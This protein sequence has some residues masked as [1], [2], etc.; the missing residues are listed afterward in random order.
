MIFNARSIGG[1]H[2]CMAH[3]PCRLPRPALHLV[4]LCYLRCFAVVCSISCFS[5]MHG[6][7]ITSAAERIVY[8]IKAWQAD[9]CC[10]ALPGS[11]EGCAAPSAGVVQHKANVRA[12]DNAYANATAN[13]N[14]NANLKICPSYKYA[15]D[16]DEIKLLRD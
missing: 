6:R 9:R 16:V 14:A 11:A 13:A 4:K 12:K 7:H 10:T 3:K 5:H 8:I 2:A 15:F 1:S